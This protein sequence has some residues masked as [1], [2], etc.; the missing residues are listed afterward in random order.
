MKM[1]NFKKTVYYKFL[2]KL[3]L[4]LN[5][6]LVPEKKKKCFSLLKNKVEN[7]KIYSYLK[8]RTSLN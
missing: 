7:I 8:L 4:L 6:K 2:N 3:K 5:T 1:K